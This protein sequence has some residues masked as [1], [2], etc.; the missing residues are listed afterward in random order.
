MGLL[1]EKISPV[2]HHRVAITST[3]ISESLDWCV[4][5]EIVGALA[6]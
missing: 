5:D 3:T 6:H 4:C 1:F 2:P